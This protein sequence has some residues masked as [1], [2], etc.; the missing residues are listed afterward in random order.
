MRKNK[1]DA[2][3]IG[4]NIPPRPRL[5]A[6]GKSIFSE[7]LGRPRII[8]PLPSSPPWKKISRNFVHV[9]KIVSRFPVARERNGT[10]SR[11]KEGEGG[12]RIDGFFFFFSKNEKATCCVVQNQWN[13]RWKFNECIRENIYT[14]TNCSDT[15]T[16]S[17]VFR[18]FREKLVAEK[19]RKR[20]REK[21]DTSFRGI[22]STRIDYL[23]GDPGN[24]STDLI[25]WIS[26]ALRGTSGRRKGKEIEGIARYTIFHLVLPVLP[27]GE[28]LIADKSEPPVILSPVCVCVRVWSL[29]VGHE[30]YCVSWS[31]KKSGERR[32]QEEKEVS[33]W[34][35]KKRKGETKRRK[36]ELGVE[37]GTEIQEKPRSNFM[38][39][40]DNFM[41]DHVINKYCVCK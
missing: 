30:I 16:V 27:A 24:R 38:Y 23:V 1:P 25:S 15:R 2:A 29:L 39:S 21:I 40:C 6:R 4:T 28:S 13:F 14:S 34:K 8:D 32:G 26:L 7:T 41:V 17:R 35:R 20:E 31:V 3:V 37:V 36:E 22:D 10:T 19:R 33:L 18:N 9:I 5:G 11:N 12:G